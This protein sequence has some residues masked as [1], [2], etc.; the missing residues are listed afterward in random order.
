MPTFFLHFALQRSGQHAFIAWI[1]KEWQGKMK[2]YNNWPPDEDGISKRYKRVEQDGSDV[3]VSIENEPF[4]DSFMPQSLF[5][6][7][8]FY[9]VYDWRYILLIRDPWNLL[10]SRLVNLFN[11]TKVVLSL[12]DVKTKAK[13]VLRVWK[14]HAKEYLGITSYLNK[15]KTI[16]VMYNDWFSSKKYRIKKANEIGFVTNGKPFKRIKRP[17]RSSFTLSQFNGRAHKMNVLKRWKE[18]PQWD[19]W[20][21]WFD[22]ET[23]YLAKKIFSE[24]KS[25][26]ALPIF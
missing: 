9:N 24:S 20:S 5:V 15:E 1:Q 18:V 21:Q 3:I 2:F 4:S 23:N 16:C 12:S 17:G 14:T 8:T 13:N 6:K 26:K 22:E 11:N 7:A 19:M 25:K 10:C